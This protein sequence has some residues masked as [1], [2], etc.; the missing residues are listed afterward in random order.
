MNTPYCGTLYCVF[1]EHDFCKDSLSD[2]NETWG[3][4]F[5]VLWSSYDDVPVILVILRHGV[6]CRFLAIRRGSESEGL[7][8]AEVVRARLRLAV[9][10]MVARLRARNWTVHYGRV[11][12]PLHYALY[13]HQ[14]CFHGR[15]PRWDERRARQRSHHWKLRASEFYFHLP[16]QFQIFCTIADPCNMLCD[17]MRCIAIQRNAMQCDTIQYNTIQYNT[18]QYT[19]DSI[20]LIAAFILF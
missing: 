8:E 6:L 15:G 19:K 4:F 1:C 20:Y 9:S 18:I 2:F 17:A 3:E 16:M 10:Y 13:R 12:R 5:F 14:H 11:R 7:R